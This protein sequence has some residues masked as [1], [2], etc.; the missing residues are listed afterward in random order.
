[1]AILEVNEV[2]SG[3]GE[4]QI[5]WGSSIKLEEGKLTCLDFVAH[6]DGPD[7]PLEGYDHLQWKGRQPG[8]GLYQG[9]DGVSPGPGRPP[10]IYRHER[11]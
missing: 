9:R 10:V 4:V 3:Y 11:L 2:T 7:P 5:L 6:G 8:T 1:M